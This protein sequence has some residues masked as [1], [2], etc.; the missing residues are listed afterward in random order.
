[1]TSELIKEN[2]WTQ[3]LPPVDLVIRTGVDNAPHWSGGLLMW[4]TAYS[5]L[6]FTN[7]YYPDFTTEDF[8]KAVEDY[9]DRDRR[10]G[11]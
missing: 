7:T 4:Q 10:F 2:L 1:M 8:K 11:S 3:S 6:H 9:Q 5:Q